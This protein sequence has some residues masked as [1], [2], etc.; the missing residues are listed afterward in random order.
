MTA[1]LIDT[2]S[3]ANELVRLCAPRGPHAPRPLP[4]RLAARAVLLKAASLSFAAGRRYPEHE[5]NER[6]QEW[7]DTVGTGLETD[8]VHLRRLLVEWGWLERTV[9]G[10]SY[11]RPA[12]APHGGDSSLPEF[13]ATVDQLDVAT[14]R[15]L[16]SAG[17]RRGN[18]R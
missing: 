5:V 12:E 13:D 11:W 6:L 7:L 17:P 2:V 3:F 8:R 9:D 15:R 1:M 4:R 14:Q 18:S 10:S 16:V